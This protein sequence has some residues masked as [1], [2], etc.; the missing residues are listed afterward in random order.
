M[1]RSVKVVVVMAVV[2][3]MCI[4][5][6]IS[7]V[8]VSGKENIRANKISA[9]D[10]WEIDDEE[11]E[12]IESIGAD[13]AKI[14]EEKMQAERISRIEEKRREEEEKKFEE[15][16]QKENSNIEY[17]ENDSKINTYEEVNE[18]NSTQE[19]E[20]YGEAGY[21]E[22]VAYEDAQI[23]NVYEI[24]SW[25]D[26]SF[27]A[28]MDYRNITAVN[29]VQYDMQY[30]WGAYTDEYGIRKIGDD[31]CVALGTGITSGCGERFRVTLDTG[32][33]FTVIVGDVKADVDTD[34]TNTYRPMG[35]ARGNVIEFI[36]DTYNMSYDVRNSGSIGT[37]EEF[38]GNVISLEKIA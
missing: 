35:G 8:A 15:M 16:V 28:Y 29:S 31:Y 30:N 5:G 38:S 1:K 25:I 20:R 27:K 11:N 32:S 26:S 2:V 24:P 7:A 4:S 37:Y 36:V 9:Q 33:T 12:R 22:E 3:I 21:Y 17:E 34:I 13:R 10:N 19:I 23:S 18:Y 14:E 6:V